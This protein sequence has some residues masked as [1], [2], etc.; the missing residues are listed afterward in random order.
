[1]VDN[2][3][4]KIGNDM[5]DAFPGSARWVNGDHL[6]IRLAWS[7]SSGAVERPPRLYGLNFEGTVEV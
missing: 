7:V 2:R 4:I 3:S 5:L 1:M 6:L